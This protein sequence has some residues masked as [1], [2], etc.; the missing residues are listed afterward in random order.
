MELQLDGR[1][2]G[3][4]DRVSHHALQYH[5]TGFIRLYQ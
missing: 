4:S 3:I 5:G 2:V 1:L